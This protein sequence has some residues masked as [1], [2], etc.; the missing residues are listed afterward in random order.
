MSDRIKVLTDENERLSSDKV[1]HEDVQSL[2]EEVSVLESANDELENMMKAKEVEI[3]TQATEFEAQLHMIEAQ[4]AEAEIQQKKIDSLELRLSAKDNSQ[5]VATLEEEIAELREAA[6]EPFNKIHEL[7]DEVV[8]HLETIGGLE[9][10]LTEAKDAAAVAPVPA[11]PL[12]PMPTPQAPPGAAEEEVNETRQMNS[13]LTTE[14]STL[15]ELYD[16]LNDKF[17]AATEEIEELKMS[18]PYVDAGVPSEGLQEAHDEMQAKYQASQDALFQQHASYEELEEKYEE[19]LSQQF[20]SDD[21][22]LKKDYGDLLVSHTNLE[23]QVTR[24]ASAKKSLERENAE[25]SVKAARGPPTPVAPSPPAPS[26]DL[27]ERHDNLSSEYSDLHSRHEELRLEHEELRLQHRTLSSSTGTQIESLTKQLEKVN[28]QR[29]VDVSA[30]RVAPHA[31]LVADHNALLSKHEELHFKHSTLSSST[32]AQIESLTKQLNEANK[33]QINASLARA[34]P[35]QSFLGASSVKRLREMQDEELSRIKKSF[36]IQVEK[37]QASHGSQ[38]VMLNEAIELSNRE[39]ER[40]GMEL[41][42]V[43]MQHEN[44]SNMYEC[45]QEELGEERRNVTKLTAEFQKSHANAAS[46]N[47]ASTTAKQAEINSLKITVDKLTSQVRSL[48]KQNDNLSNLEKALNLNPS[49]PPQQKMLQKQK[50]ELENDM[51][52]MQAHYEG[53]LKNAKEENSMII[54]LAEDEKAALVG[55]FKVGTA[56][57]FEMFSKTIDTTNARLNY[58]LTASSKKIVSIEA[59]LSAL[60]YQFSSNQADLRK[61]THNQKVALTEVARMRRKEVEDATRIEELTT[62]LEGERAAAEESRDLVALAY[63]TKAGNSDKQLAAALTA[64]VSRCTDV[65]LKKIEEL[66]DSGEKD[67]GFVKED[68]ENAMVV[69]GEVKKQLEMT[70]KQNHSLEKRC[71]MAEGRLNATLKLASAHGAACA[72]ARTELGGKKREVALWKE[73]A[74]EREKENQKLQESVAKVGE[75]YAEAMFGLA[76]QIRVSEERRLSDLA[77]AKK[78]VESANKKAKLIENEIEEIHIDSDGVAQVLDGKLKSKEDQLAL[79]EEGMGGLMGSLE[80]LKEENEGLRGQ[81]KENT[82]ETRLMEEENRALT[83]KLEIVG[84]MLEVAN[85]KVDMFEED[86][87][88][89]VEELA[90]IKEAEGDLVARL[91]EKEEE[92][93]N[94]KEKKELVGDALEITNRKLDILEE[95]YDTLKESRDVLRQENAGL[96]SVGRSAELKKEMEIVDVNNELAVVA[97]KKNFLENEKAF[98]EKT[99]TDLRKEIVDLKANVKEGNRREADAKEVNEMMASQIDELK[100]GASLSK[101]ALEAA[102][103]FWEESEEAAESLR[104]DIDDLKKEKTK[105]S[106]ELAEAKQE[107]FFYSDEMGTERMKRTGLESLVS[108]I[109]ARNEEL[110]V[111]VDEERAK[112]I[113][114]IQEK[115]TVVGKRRSDVNTLSQDLEVSRIEAATLSSEVESYKSLIAELREKVHSFEGVAESKSLDLAEL[116]EQNRLWRLRNIKFVS[117]I[118]A[119]ES[120][121]MQAEKERDEAASQVQGLKEQIRLIQCTSRQYGTP[122]KGGGTDDSYAVRIDSPVVT[123][124]VDSEEYAMA[125]DENNQVRRNEERSLK[126]SYS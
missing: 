60:R 79:M 89:K 45:L 126:R 3:S 23:S 1:S 109:E 43:E 116:Q 59:I 64:E 19:L 37:I 98:L 7:S 87:N 70:L 108:E 97:E 112:V 30:A 93:A 12:S 68:F 32:E 54:N 78:K 94:S 52:E 99:I 61:S 125:M 80:A 4:H 72:V 10:Q 95:E 114:L 83:G 62:R 38:L 85:R 122:I 65:Q 29:R 44:L 115:N 6:V 2:R 25:L 27:I 26:T 106:D 75:N 55:G 22:Q 11:T 21:E 102:E 118:A 67:M 20:S 41:K 71:I 107:I 86:E 14:L 31:A 76:E 91:E 15:N 110:K 53:E 104:D 18:K 28:T 119:V 56:E 77:S 50:V 66:K 13:D 90:R 8:A 69:Y 100:Q 58:K 40:A 33:Q 36:S 81:V 17:N 117:E 82:E 47:F 96:R 121:K 9:Q 42:M 63:A 84:D 113:G 35:S 88:E 46:S 24:L 51:Y 103:Q 105:L 120:R 34:T 123:K 49:T 16:D 101:T 57:L 124:L 74:E 48:T 5:E 39:L 73:R 92:L 111:T